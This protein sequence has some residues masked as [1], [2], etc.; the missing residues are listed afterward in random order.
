MTI[1]A[2]R[3]SALARTSRRWA[4]LA[5]LAAVG[6][7]VAACASS[8][9]TNAGSGGGSSLPPPAATG[10]ALAAA[11]TNLGTILVD[12]NGHTVYE[13]A[14]DKPG[15]SNCTGSCLQYWPIVTAPATL[16]ASVP[17]VDAKVGEITRSDGMKQL[18]VNGWPVYTYYKDTAAGATAGQGTNINGG[19]W[20][21]VAPSGSLIKTAA[22][23][24]PTT[25][26]STSKS[27]GGGGGWA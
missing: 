5:G 24:S 25:A 12:G 4:P 21:V 13:F 3:T 16:P 6:L 19:L 9:G 23:S 14:S 1:T 7:V 20:W 27:S 11:R 8:S 15:V 26:P 2:A 22:G 10:Q 18:T 17:G